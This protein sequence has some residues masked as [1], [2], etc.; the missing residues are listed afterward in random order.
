MIGPRLAIGDDRDAP[1]GRPE[2]Q[3]RQPAP[4]RFE[5]IAVPKGSMAGVVIGVAGA[6][7]SFGLVWHMWWLAI[8]GS[9]AVVVALILRSFVRGAEREIP[10]REV[11]RTEA[12][13]REAIRAARPIP[14]QV[15]MTAA[16]R[17]VAEVAA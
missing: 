17:G 14:R 2:P 9:L 8:V 4:E 12:C 3:A 5:A 15:E 11:A 10:A 7:A 16:N 6:I 1:Q 13:W